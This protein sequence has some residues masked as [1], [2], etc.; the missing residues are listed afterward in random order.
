[1]FSTV[2]R[3]AAQLAL[4]GA[5][6][7]LAGASA[8]DDTEIHR[9]Q[10]DDGTIAFQ[11]MPCSE[12]STDASDGP[13]PGERPGATG[14]SVDDDDVFDFVNPFDEPDSAQSSIDP[15]VPEPV[16][17]DRVEC[18]KMTR[19]A[20]DA[21]D[22]EMRDTAYTEEEGKAYLAEL[23]TLT[24]AAAR[25]QAIVGTN[26]RVTTRPCR[27]R[28]LPTMRR[29]HPNRQSRSAGSAGSRPRSLRHSFAPQPNRPP[30][31]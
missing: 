25:L 19:D 2:S 8:A 28:R 10:Q 12:A 20:I 16:S 9:C 27:P 31:R 24:R 17:Q 5:V 6:L 26:E 21:I 14:L 18:E 23:L 15:E 22:L 13:A 3:I 4:C 11:E 7:L 29:P 1:M 30:A